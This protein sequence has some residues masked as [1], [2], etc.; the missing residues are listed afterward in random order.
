MGSDGLFDN[1]YDLEIENTLRI[2]TISDQESAQCCGGCFTSLLSSSWLAIFLKLHISLRRYKHLWYKGAIMVH[3]GLYAPWLWSLLW[4]SYKSMCLMH[5]FWWW[6][7]VEIA[8]NAL[9]ALASKNSRDTTY[10]SPYIKEAV[11]QVRIYMSYQCKHVYQPNFLG[12]TEDVLLQ[13][14]K[15]FQLLFLNFY[16]SAVCRV[17]TCHGTKKY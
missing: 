12:T 9:A 14:C 6:K 17:W 10:E 15:L 7:G 13:V 1:V 3:L 2:F 4:I 16:H 8:A 5:S 11:Q